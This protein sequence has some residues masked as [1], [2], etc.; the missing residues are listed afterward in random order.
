MPVT[1]VPVGNQF[2]R[3]FPVP[4]DKSFVFSTTQERLN[5]ASNPVAYSG[6]VAADLETNKVYVLGSGN[7]WV[8]VGT[9]TLNDSFTG[10]GIL[11]KTANNTFKTGGLASGNNITISNPSGLT[12]NPTIGLSS[13][14]TGITSITGV[15]GFRIASNSGIS[16]DAGAGVV[17]V[18]DLSVTGTMYIGGNIDITVAAAIL[19]QGP[20]VYSG[21]PT[22][23]SGSVYYAQTP[24]VG[25]TG[26][27]LGTNLFPVSLSGHQHS[28]SDITN[29]CSGVASCVDTTLTANTGVQFIYDSGTD[30]LSI[31]LTGQALAFHTLNNNGLVVRSAQNTVVARAITASGANIWIGNGDGVSNNPTVGLNPNVTVTSVT[32]D[33]ITVVNNLTVN[34]TTV[35]A[36]VESIVVEDPILT[37]G[38]SSGTIVANT[39]YDRGLALVIATG[40]TA[41]MGYDQS[42]S[43]FVMLSSGVATNSSGNYDAGTYGT[44]RVGTYESETAT[45]NSLAVFNSSK[46]LVSSGIASL[47]PSGRSITPGSGLDGTTALTLNQDITLNVGQGDGITV[48][49]NTVAVDSTVVRTSSVQFITGVKSFADRPIFASGIT[50]TG[51]VARITAAGSAGTYFPV[52]SSDPTSSAQAVGVRTTSELRSDLSINNV[53]NDAQVKKRASSTDGYVPT[54]SG[55]TGDSLNNGY[56]ATSTNINSTLVVRD[57]INGGFNA[58][59]ITATGFI[60][61]GGGLTGL[62]ANNI[63]SGT[64][65]SAVLTGTYNISIT[66]SAYST[67]GSLTF[68]NDGTGDAANTSFSGLVSRTVSYNTI[69][70]PSTT[71]AN[72]SGSNWNI[73]ILGNAATVTNG[74]Y[75]TR[76]LTAGSGLVGGGDLSSNR[77]FDIVG[78]D[79]ISVSPDAISLD[80]TVVR[81]T[82]VQTING[83]KTFNNQ[84]VF[85]SGILAGGP[86]RFTTGQGGFDFTID[87]GDLTPGLDGDALKLD[88]DI[89]NGLGYTTTLKT[90]APGQNITVLLPGNSGT[91]ITNNDLANISINAGS[92]LSGGGNIGQTRT[93]NI[94][95]GDGISVSADNIAVDNTVVRTTGIQ[96]I[97]GV[98]TFFN[99]PIFNSGITS[100]GTFSVLAASASSPLG[101]AVFDATPTGTAQSLVYRTLANVRSDLGASINTVSTLVLRD[102]NGD[103]ASRYIT[104]TGISGVQTVGNM[105]NVYTSTSISGINNTTYLA[106]FIIDGGTP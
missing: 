83:V 99:T 3:N 84:P 105:T 49:S 46:Q 87:R 61:Y 74:V 65:P 54:W 24:Y 57:G 67:T 22:I 45:A 104:V 39:S 71:G 59:T 26:G 52:F 31:A 30:N 91:L 90:S 19:A 23:Y 21:N 27:T 25:P 51:I 28:Y 34:G 96:N 53:T 48:G 36:N 89:T 82:G 85:N 1:V 70:A 106:N 93:I 11:F 43:K 47:V 72:A 63:A 9:S 66:G 95:G 73:S 88:V 12:A 68:K 15:N 42:A 13:N 50:T 92:G 10:S 79:G 2:T 55:T 78:G 56:Q 40:Q 20:I 97:S 18:D 17:S 103:F 98:K 94:G 100:S 62:Y 86:N 58:G 6:L 76:T 33:D 4:L 38:Q 81:T 32:T 60:G 44:L 35:I 8:E 41:F 101:F 14:I 69:G 5:Y 29:F 77:T 75:T 80:T 16:I 102:S 64:I 37:L 7:V